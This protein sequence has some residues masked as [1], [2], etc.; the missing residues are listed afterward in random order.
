MSQLVDAVVGELKALRKGRGLDSSNTADRT[1]PELRAAC[2]ITEK[3]GPAQA[4]DKLATKLDPLTTYLPPDLRTA[5]RA[6]LGLCEEAR[7][8]LYQERVKWVAEQLHHDPRTARRRIDDGIRHLAQ[9]IVEPPEAG[10]H[11]SELHV[12]V[13]L[14]RHPSTTVE[15]RTIVSDQ[16]NLTELDLAVTLASASD[17]REA[18]KIM[19]V[20]GGHLTGSRLESSTRLGFTLTLPRPL[21]RGERHV[22]A[23]EYAFPGAAEPDPYLACVPRHR[24]DVFDLRVRFDPARTPPHAWLLAATLQRDTNDEHAPG[25]QLRV[26]PEGELHVTFRDLRPGLAYGLRW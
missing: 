7:H 20:H 8:R 15:R 2:G 25:T 4:R 16:P 17:P 6:A 21:N 9:L 24:C 18:L 12:L 11:T 26:P 1:G 19:T 13:A 23:V 14:D 10:W 22:Y 3:D 5:V